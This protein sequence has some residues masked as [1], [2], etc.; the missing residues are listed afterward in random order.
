[1]G[2]WLGCLVPEGLEVS[3]NQ[4]PQNRQQY[5][6]FFIVRA[7]TKEPLVRLN[8]QVP[9]AL[10]LWLP[11]GWG[12]LSRT[13]VWEPPE[14]EALVSEFGAAWDKGKAC[15]VRLP[16]L[17]LCIFWESRQSSREVG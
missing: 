15:S 17:A 16:V 13:S 11:L 5:A 6:T 12:P 14:E 7:P 10:C 9:N 2:C 8:L 3:K 4:G 1:M